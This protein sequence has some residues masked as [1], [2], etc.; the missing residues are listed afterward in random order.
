M[1]IAIGEMLCVAFRL[2]MSPEPHVYIFWLNGV[3]AKIVAKAENDIT[4][5]MCKVA[6]KLKMFPKL[7]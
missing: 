5:H 7:K 6:P 4:V 3:K 1:S 2:K